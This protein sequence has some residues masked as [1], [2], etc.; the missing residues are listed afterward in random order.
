VVVMSIGAVEG[1]VVRVDGKYVVDLRGLICPYPQLYTAKVIKSV[2]NGAVVE[3][4]VD[5][6][7]SCQT[8]PALASRLGCSVIDVVQAD[9][10]WV[11]RIKKG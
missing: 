3:V 9:G 5:Y 1:K 7:Q 10:Y 4:L 8:V 6:P 2:E 11:I